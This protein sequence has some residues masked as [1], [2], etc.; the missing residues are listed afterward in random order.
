MTAAIFHIEPKTIRETYR[1]DTITIKYNPQQKVWG[2]RVI[3]HMSVQLEGVALTMEKAKK[4]AMKK[5]DK[6]KGE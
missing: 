6:M 4:E 5:I 2:W 3:H 1:G